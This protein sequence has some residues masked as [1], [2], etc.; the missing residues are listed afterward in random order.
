M[1][2]PFTIELPTKQLSAGTNTIS[3]RRSSRKDTTPLYVTALAKARATGDAVQ[4]ASHL[5][6]ISR[7]F[8]RLTATPTVLGPVRTIAEKQPLF[9]TARAGEQVNARLTIEVPHEL[10]YVMVKVPK[11]AGC[12][13]LNALSGWDATISRVLDESESKSSF[14][15]NNQRSLYREEHDDHSAFFIDHIQ[16]G[17]WEIDFA[18]RAVTAGNYRALPAVIEAMY[19]PEVRAN[20]DSRRMQITPSQLD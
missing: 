8:E 15:Y 10:N 19:V 7:Q 14:R 6:E 17:T 9:S 5:V 18:L 12:E 3:V 20:S 2:E 4:P 11:P 16:P 1:A 13:P